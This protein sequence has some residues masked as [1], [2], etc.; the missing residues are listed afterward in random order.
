MNSADT[1]SGRTD[2]ALLPLSAFDLRA[3]EGPF[4]VQLCFQVCQLLTDIY[5]LR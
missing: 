4:K 1:K 5:F 3:Y 2:P